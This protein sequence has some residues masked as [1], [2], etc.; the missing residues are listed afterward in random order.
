MK[1]SLKIFV[2]AI[3]LLTFISSVGWGQSDGDYQSR[4]S[5]VWNSTVGWKKYNSSIP[6]WENTSTPPNNT[7]GKIEILAAHTITLTTSVTV[8]ELT[9]NGT[10]KVDGYDLNHGNLTIANGSD[11]YD[12][13]V[14]G[15]IENADGVI[16]KNTGA[17]VDFF[18]V[19]KHVFYLE[20]GTIPS[21]NWNTG[22]ECQVLGYDEDTDPIAAPDGLNQNFCS[23]T[24]SCASQPSDINMFG[25]LS[26]LSGFLRVN[27]TNNYKLIL[28]D[29]TSLNLGIGGDFIL[30]GSSA[31]INVS[32][33]SSSGST[34][35]INLIGVFNQSNGVFEFTNNSGDILNVNFNGSEGAFTK[36]GGTL[37]GTNINWN[38]NSGKSLTLNNNFSLADNRTFTV[39]G[40]IDCSSYNISGS[41]GTTFTINSGAILKTSNSNGITSSGATGSIQTETRN[42]NSGSSYEYYGSSAQVTGSGLPSEVTN[43]TINNS[44]GVTLTNDVQVKGTLTF[45]NGKLIGITNDKT[46]TLGYNDD[47]TI[48]TGSIS[49]ESSSKYFVGLFSRWISSAYTE[50]KFPIGNSDYY[51]PATINYTTV[52]SNLGTLS[53]EFVTENPGS[54]NLDSLC[55]KDN[56]LISDYWINCYSTTGYWE[57]GTGNSLSGG[58]YSIS[59]TG[60]SFPF[61][62]NYQKIHLLKRENG[63]T[64]TWTLEG[65][66]SPAT[67][68]NSEPVGKRTGLTAYS[69]FTFSS[70]S[71]DNNFQGPLPVTLASFNSNVNGKNILLNWTTSEEI[72]NSGFDIERK[73]SD[74]IW[75]KI[76]FVKGNGTKNTSTT[77]SYEDRNLISG[78]YNYRLKQIDYNGNYEYYELNGFVEIGVPSKFDIGQNYPNPFNPV[79]KINYE[80]PKDVK[81]EIKV[82]D[83]SG[84]E[85]KSLVNE[86]KSAGYHTIEFNGS[87][88][89]SGIYFY[90]IKADGFLKTLKMSLVK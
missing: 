26:S 82:Y 75:N 17:Y 13:I 37:T 63:S 18:G 73:T 85:I 38:V 42:F 54:P 72:N 50:Y 47:G 89:S 77:Y 25:Q 58:N 28:T 24:W 15:V 78:K 57:V 55:D 84:R 60:T 48:Y 9:I 32:N 27:N 67:G 11:P 12:V 52:P 6:G 3:L 68:S 80:L 44:A 69:Q 76:A 74:G 64:N 46:V 81:V 31:K 45:S 5:T 19:Y 49:G 1:N 2:F 34:Y 90:T 21:F 71:N 70:N 86:L 88:L 83:I 79:T 16:T 53:V 59:L 39:N 51:R 20:P 40:T 14:Y 29:N 33:G 7:N 41:T 23:F 87:G 22:S 65:N 10:L 4:R 8:D 43:L 36:T 30:D 56:D 61:I 62:T 35:N 66:H